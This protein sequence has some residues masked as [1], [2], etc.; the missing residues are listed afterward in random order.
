M[1]RKRDIF[2]FFRNSQH[3][4]NEAP[5]ARSWRRLE[6]RLDAHRS[7]NRIS[8][9]RAAG[10][11]AGILLLVTL[12][13][14]VSLS[15]GR[16]QR[17]LLAANRQAVPSQVEDLTLTD[18]DRSSLGAVLA[19]QQARGNPQHPISEGAPGQKLV[20]ASNRGSEPG[21]AGARLKAFSWMIGRWQSRETGQMAFE[22]WKR[23]SDSEMAGLARLD[24]ETKGQENMRLYEQGNK[25]CFSTDFGGKETV[26]YT[27]IALN[28]EEA[29]FENLDAGF[30]QQV[31]L[32]HEGRGQMSIVFQN[33]ESELPDTERMR[34]IRKRH[35]IQSMQAA[36]RL[37]RVNLQ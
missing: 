23:L 7:R 3:R 29:L 37:G 12:V 6:R 4:L 20:L 26:A 36:R 14:L 28:G 19:V 17:L 15:L 11:A 31:R 35:T 8:R 27:L 18:A 33:A 16:H 22:E 34:N 5:P 21:S 32:L 9:Y 30:P 25:L 24:N 2:D 10:M 13:G 1:A